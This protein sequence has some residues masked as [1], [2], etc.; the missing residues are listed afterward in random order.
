MCR[1]TLSS[2]MFNLFFDIFYTEYYHIGHIGHI[3]GTAAL[4]LYPNATRRGRGGGGVQGKTVKYMK[5]NI[6]KIFPNMSIF[7]LTCEHPPI[8]SMTFLLTLQQ[9][10][11]CPCI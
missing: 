3:L 2:F 8:F 6:Q 1:C 7:T 11:F 10:I 4:R 5:R 9:P